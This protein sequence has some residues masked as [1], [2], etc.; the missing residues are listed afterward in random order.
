[1]QVIQAPIIIIVILIQLQI[2]DSIMSFQAHIIE[3]IWGLVGIHYQLQSNGAALIRLLSNKHT[4]L[5]PD[6]KRAIGRNAVAGRYDREEKMESPNGDM[7]E[8]SF[9]DQ[10]IIKCN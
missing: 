7:S 9:L 2:R 8:V 10:G 3:K 1:M 6:L 4:F 5:D